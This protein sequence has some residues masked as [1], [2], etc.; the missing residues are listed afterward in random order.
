[1]CIRLQ[2]GACICDVLTNEEVAIAEVNKLVRLGQI[3]HFSHGQ[4]ARMTLACYLSCNAL[5]TP[6]R[7]SEEICSHLT[8][9][10]LAICGGRV[11]TASQTL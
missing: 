6:G 11:W 10:G 1:M 2:I 5:S 7:K 9:T 4:F 3:M 8:Y